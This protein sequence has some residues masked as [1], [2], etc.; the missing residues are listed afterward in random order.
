MTTAMPPP[1]ATPINDIISAR[2]ETTMD[3]RGIRMMAI[4][5]NQKKALVK[6]MV[7]YSFSSISIS[8]WLSLMESRLP[9]AMRPPI[10]ANGLDMDWSNGRGNPNGM[11]SIFLWAIRSPFLFV[12]CLTFPLFSLQK[13]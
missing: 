8:A 12:P 3:S 10:D 2:L 13:R 7:A 6:T 4:K 9:L 5:M 1:M 11:D